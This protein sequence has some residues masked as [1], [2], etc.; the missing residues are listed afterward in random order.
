MCDVIYQLL[1]SGYYRIG[2]GSGK[3]GNAFSGRLSCTKKQFIIPRTN[4]GREIREIGKSALQDL[5]LTSLIIL[6]PLT[7]IEENG[8]RNLPL[9]ELILPPTLKTLKEYAV[10]HFPKLELLILPKG[11][12]ISS[13]KESFL[14]AIQSS[15]CTI[16]Y[17]GYD[18]FD[19]VDFRLGRANLTIQVPRGGS[20]KFGT[21]STVES[22]DA[23]ISD[24]NNMYS[25]K[26]TTKC[27]TNRYTLNVLIF[28][29]ICDSK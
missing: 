4:E 5:S 20:S 14:G 9:A 24:I 11:L 22:E 15:A 8:I 2:D 12:K 19:L 1:P 29:I 28:H 18:A 6:A 13:Y 7:K 10:Y 21:K 17:C 16:K 25:A 23:C 3:Y 26:A 27:R